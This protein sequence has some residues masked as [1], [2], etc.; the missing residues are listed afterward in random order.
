M[1]QERHDGGH[2]FLALID[3][4]AVLH[5]ADHIEVSFHAGFRGHATVAIDCAIPRAAAA[6]HLQPNA[7]QIVV[8]GVVMTVPMSSVRTSAGLIASLHGP[9]IIPPPESGFGVLIWPWLQFGDPHVF[10]GAALIFWMAS[11]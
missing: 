2:D 5:L 11:N 10:Y 6:F 7:V 8:V 1:F 3:V 4:A 9:G